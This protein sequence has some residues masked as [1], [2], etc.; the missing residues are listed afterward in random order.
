MRLIALGVLLAGCAPS[1]EA[2]FADPPELELG[3]G[4]KDFRPIGKVGEAE[5]VYGTQGGHHIDLAFL[6]RGLHTRE[7]V[8]GAGLGFV[9]GVHVGTM[10]GWVQFRCDAD[11]GRAEAFGVRLIFDVPPSEIDGRDVEIEAELTDVDGLS[12]SAMGSVRVVDP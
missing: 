3:V 2:C 10:D 4:L 1:D 11:A 12:A 5:L 6:A 9:D 8:T 7:L